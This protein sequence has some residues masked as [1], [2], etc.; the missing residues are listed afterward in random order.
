MFVIK[1]WHLER[2]RWLL[3]LPKIRSNSGSRSGFS[4]IFDSGF[5]YEKKRGIPADSTPVL[6]TRSCLC[7]LSKMRPVFNLP[8]SASILRTHEVLLTVREQAIMKQADS[9][10]NGF[11]HAS[12]KHIW[13]QHSVRSTTP[14]W[15]QHLQPST[16]AH[17]ETN[18]CHGRRKEGLGPPGF[19]KF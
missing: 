16:N 18:P 2:P 4:Q 3:L 8:L 6:R 12:R 19:W 9:G 13:L 14:T 15:R 11:L 1:Q 17:T 5:G 10:W 7:Y